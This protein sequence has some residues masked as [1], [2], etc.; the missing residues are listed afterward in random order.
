MEVP[1]GTLPIGPCIPLIALY[2]ASWAFCA[3]LNPRA[4]AAATGVP[5]PVADAYEATT[6]PI[7]PRSS[8]LS[9]KS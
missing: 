4:V 7:E 6:L 8:A 2:L 5:T 9:L 1:S 3:A